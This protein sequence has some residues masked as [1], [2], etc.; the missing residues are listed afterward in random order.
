MTNKKWYKTW[1]GA[2]L[3]VVSCIMLLLMLVTWLSEFI[4][5]SAS[6]NLMEIAGR[7]FTVGALVLVGYTVFNRKKK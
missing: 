3:V 5:A 2:I 4:G 6:S 7:L 1:W